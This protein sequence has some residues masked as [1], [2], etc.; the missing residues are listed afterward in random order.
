LIFIYP[1]GNEYC[2]KKIYSSFTHLG[3]GHYSLLLSSYFYRSIRR[4]THFEGMR[5]SNAMALKPKLKSINIKVFYP[6]RSAHKSV[7]VYHACPHC[8]VEDWGSVILTE[9][10]RI[11]ECDNCG[12]EYILTKANPQ[13]YSTVTK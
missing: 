5:K 7:S 10:N 12:R 1:F 13:C 4:N 3:K 11:V 2:S 8:F 6:I 9:E